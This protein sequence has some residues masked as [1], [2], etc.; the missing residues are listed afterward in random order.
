[1]SD[2]KTSNELLQ[3]IIDAWEA[4]PGNLNRSSKAVQS[5]LVGDMLP[6]INQ[7]RDHLLDREE[8]L[9]KRS[10]LKCENCREP[11]VCENEHWDDL[12]GPNRAGWSCHWDWN[13]KTKR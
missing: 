13:G 11:V 8:T 3:D 9:K 2:K 7:I 10:N 5:W 4:L 12:D 1:M 6:V